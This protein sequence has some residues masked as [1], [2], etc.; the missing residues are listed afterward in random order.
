MTG[1]QTCA[2]PISILYYTILYYTIL[3]YTILYYT[4]V[5]ISYFEQWNSGDNNVYFLGEL[6]KEPIFGRL[7]LSPIEQGVGKLLVSALQVSSLQCP[8]SVVTILSS[9][10][11][12]LHTKSSL[13]VF[14]VNYLTRCSIFS[15]PIMAVFGRVVFG[16]RGLLN[17][18]ER[19]LVR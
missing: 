6:K 7:L 14:I 1:V 19:L 18:E 16:S 2:L 10:F 3:Y 15:M 8:V 5:L 11:T 17:A 9:T 4:I 12:T 13:I